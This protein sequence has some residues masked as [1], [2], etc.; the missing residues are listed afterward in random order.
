MIP[1]ART[2]AA[3]DSFAR[4]YSFY[5]SCLPSGNK[6]LYFSDKYINTKYNMTCLSFSHW[7]NCT[8]TQTKENIF[9]E[10]SCIFL[11]KGKTVMKL[12]NFIIKLLNILF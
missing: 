5:S 3:M 6:Y 9:P 12:N 10:E 11:H 8:N 7:Y 1:F 2:A 4:A